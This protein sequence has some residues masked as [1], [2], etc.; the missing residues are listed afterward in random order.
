[1][2]FINILRFYGMTSQ[3]LLSGKERFLIPDG[4][5]RDS[6]AAG[7]AE[8]RI[9]AERSQ[10]TKAPWQKMIFDACIS[11]VVPALIQRRVGKPPAI[12]PSHKVACQDGVP[13][14]SAGS[15]AV[16][17]WHYLKNRV[18]GAIDMA[19]GAT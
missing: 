14:I 5:S 19:S 9:G 16:R 13:A 8:F 4:P 2:P 1:M 10:I 3:P 12:D 11:R 17:R 15:T 18:L 7:R 6:T